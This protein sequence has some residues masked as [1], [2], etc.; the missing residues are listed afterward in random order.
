MTTQ[1][2][3]GVREQLAAIHG[4]E[5]TI[6]LGDDAAQNLR[7]S[8]LQ[9]EALSKSGAYDKV[10][11]IN[12]PFSRRRFT[13]AAK[14]LEWEPTGNNIQYLQ[15][16]QGKL[17]DTARELRGRM[18]SPERTAIIINSWELASSCYR[19]REE[20]IFT[21]HE[22]A[23]GMGVTVIVYACNKPQSVSVGKVN[24]TGLG[25]LAVSADAVISLEAPTIEEEI[26]PVEEVKAEEISATPSAENVIPYASGEEISAESVNSS[27]NKTNDLTT[28]D[29]HLLA[30]KGITFHQ[31]R[32]YAERQ[33]K[34]G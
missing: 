14:E 10:Y 33:R 30:K 29:M 13:D 26:V 7:A 25:K 16:F 23:I 4:G 1:F 24:R 11:Y 15:A 28:A 31:P 34:K 2:T 22:L 3:S 20:L 32:N 6:V 18:K 12:L 19:Y 9:T 21:L 5:I 17:M 8:I 27:P